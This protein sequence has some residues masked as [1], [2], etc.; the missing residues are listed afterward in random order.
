LDHLDDSAREVHLFARP[1]RR[2]AVTEKAILDDTRRFDMTLEMNAISNAL[3][4]F[5]KLSPEARARAYL[6]LGSVLGV[7]QSNSQTT[8]GGSKEGTSTHSV[9]ARAVNSSKSL[10]GDFRPDC[11]VF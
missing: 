11:I 10:S 5:E 7:A 2:N 1:M 9:T 8:R 4:L 3:K 6:Y